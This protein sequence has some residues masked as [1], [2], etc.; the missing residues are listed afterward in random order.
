MSKVSPDMRRKLNK[1]LIKAR[2]AAQTPEA[3]AKRLATF[4]RNRA[5]K[6]AAQART[7]REVIPVEI[8]PGEERPN[9]RYTHQLGGK[10]AQAVQLKAS[11]DQRLDLAKGLLASLYEGIQ[12]VRELAGLPVGRKVKS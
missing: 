10:K 9:I 12:T 4:K 6:L 8:L 2:K 5:E 7:G 11:T 1:N 3:R